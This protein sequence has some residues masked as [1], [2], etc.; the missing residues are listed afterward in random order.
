MEDTPT[1]SQGYQVINVYIGK[2]E[3]D[4]RTKWEYEARRRGMTV[5]Q[6]VRTAVEWFIGNKNV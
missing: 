6:F 4:L 2:A 1:R 3:D 5:S